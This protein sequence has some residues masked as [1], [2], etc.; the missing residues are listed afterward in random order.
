MPLFKPAAYN[1]SAPSLRLA[2]QC[3]TPIAVN[4]GL[5][6]V[7]IIGAGASGLALAKTLYQAGIPF[8]CFETSDRVGG[9]WA[10]KNKSGKSAAYRSLHA[11]TSRDRTSYSD[12]PFPEN[13]PDFPHHTQLAQYLDAYVDWFGF[14]DKIQFE[15][16]VESVRR[17]DEAIWEVTLN[18]GERRRYDAVCVAS[19]Q[20]WHPLWPDPRPPGG[21][22]GVEIHSKDYVDPT[23]PL[24]LRGKRVL[25]VGFGN[26]ALDIA[27]ELGR[28]EN[29]AMVYVSARRGRWVI[30]RQF[31]ARAW[32]AFYPH[33]A[34]ASAGS[35]QRSLRTVLRSLAPR[36]LREWIRL[37]R[38]EAAIGLP[39]Q[40]GLAKPAEP[41]FEAWPVIS[42]ELYQ[43]LAAG[44]LAVKPDVAAYEGPL[45]RFTDQ[46]S[47]EV[48]AIIYCTGYKRA[49]PF[50]EPSFA[51]KR[52]DSASRWM[53]IVDP[54]QA[55]LFFVGFTNPGCA[56]MPMSEQQAIFIRDMLLSRF[57]PPSQAAMRQELAEVRTRMRQGE[58]FPRW[59]AENIDCAAYVGALR[60]AARD[61]RSDH[62]PGPSP[63]MRTRS[64]DSDPVEADQHVGA[65]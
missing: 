31:G 60:R 2:P 7:C 30:P 12:F 35:S 25:V 17:R 29:C 33:P 14:R 6:R 64:G 22:A 27:C 32:D 10:F 38:L 23:E 20:F 59:Y 8:D 51:E 56:V 44:D 16:T 39:H 46:S 45:V 65:S 19:G 53:Q 28:K 34:L 49:F 54:D 55:N 41:Y 58:D 43:R 52:Q 37:W 21:F 15:R 24:D 5:P 11:N 9:L 36:R 47:A 48:D 61:R 26:S 62:S 42:S 1:R 3:K 18:D 57:A 63:G 13:W 40:H 4:H 50:L